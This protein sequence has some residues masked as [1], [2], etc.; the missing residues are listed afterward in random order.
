MFD[1][2]EF[3]KKYSIKNGFYIPLKEKEKM[4]ITVSG[5]AGAGK[6]SLA[7]VLVKKHNFRKISLAD[8]L[9]EICSEVFDIPMSSF[10]DRDKKDSN[11]QNPFVPTKQDTIDLIANTLNRVSKQYSFPDPVPMPTVTLVTPRDVL[12]WAGTEVIRKYC[13]N[14]IWIEIA[15]QK[16]KKLDQHC[17]IPDVRFQNER[18]FFQDKA[19]M[20]LVKRPN[21]PVIDPSENTGQDVEYDVIFSNDTG[22]Q[23]FQASV[24]L[25]FTLRRE[26]LYYGS[27]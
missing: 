14:D 8:S 12:K 27:R 4:I 1:Y 18:D 3:C 16:A 25:W 19:T 23:E 20:I 15:M 22:L 17:I 13:G 9:R 5:L 11:L 6:D 10:L 21:F 26:I 2:A 7:D 24:D